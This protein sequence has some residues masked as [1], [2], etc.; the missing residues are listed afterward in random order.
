MKNSTPSGKKCCNDAEH[1]HPL[2]F[3]NVP[4]PLIFRGGFLESHL[5]SYDFVFG[6]RVLTYWENRGTSDCNH[7]NG[8][9]VGIENYWLLYQHELKSGYLRKFVVHK[10]KC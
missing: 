2:C 4:L 5:S 6:K 3:W 10:R 8:F 7:M 9:M 1:P